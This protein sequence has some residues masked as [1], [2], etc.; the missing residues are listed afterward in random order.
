MIDVGDA[1]DQHSVERWGMFVYAARGPSQG[2][3]YEDVLFSG[4][5][6][7]GD[8]TREIT[9]FYSGSGTYKVRF[10]SEDIGSWTFVTSSNAEELEGARGGFECIVPSHRNQ[11]PVQVDGRHFIHADD[12][13]FFPFGTTSYA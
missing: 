4:T 3:P 1:T 7:P 9:G 12:M 6:T 8:V 13:S 2:N 11:G 10:M 5:F